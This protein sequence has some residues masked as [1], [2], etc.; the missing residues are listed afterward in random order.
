[1]QMHWQIWFKKETFVCVKIY[2]LCH[3]PDNYKLQITEILGV[4]Q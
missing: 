2:L 1:M 4:N 3:I